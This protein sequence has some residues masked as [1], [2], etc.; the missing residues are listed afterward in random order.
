MYI[1]Y[2]LQCIHSIFD[3]DVRSFTAYVCDSGQPY[4]LL[5]TSFVIG[6]WKN[7]FFVLASP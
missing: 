2:L 7:P 4:L 1:Q 5:L 3:R 6:Y